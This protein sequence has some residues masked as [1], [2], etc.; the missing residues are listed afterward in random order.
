MNSILE[1]QSGKSNEETYNNR[2][3][4]IIFNSDVFRYN[5]EL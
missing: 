4:L 2:A 1:H 5:A 3:R